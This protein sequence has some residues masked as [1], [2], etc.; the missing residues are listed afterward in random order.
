[1]QEIIDNLKV[2]VI[3]YLPK[4]VRECHHRLIESMME[5]RKDLI[6]PI[7]DVLGQ[8]DKLIDELEDYQKSTRMNTDF[9]M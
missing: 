1:M 7:E 5:I 2:D 6:R 9:F 3:H 8:L 4:L